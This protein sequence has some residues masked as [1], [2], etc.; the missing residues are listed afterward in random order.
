[1]PSGLSFDEVIEET[2]I[3]VVHA[4]GDTLSSYM[5]ESGS[6]HSNWQKPF[7]ILRKKPTPHTTDESGLKS[8]LREWENL[9]SKMDADYCLGP[10][11]ICRSELA[12]YDIETPRFGIRIYI[13]GIGCLTVRRIETLRNS[14][15]RLYTDQFVYEL[16]PEGTDGSGMLAD[17]LI[18]TP[19]NRQDLIWNLATT[20]LGKI[21]GLDS[22]TDAEGNDLRGIPFVSHSHATGGLCA[23]ACLFMIQSLNYKTTDAVRG[24]AEITFRA[25]SDSPQ[26]TQEVPDGK[27]KFPIKGMKR[28]Q[29]LGY[30]YRSFKGKHEIVSDVIDKIRYPKYAGTIQVPNL[31]RIALEAYS[32]SRIPQIACIDMKKLWCDQHEKVNPE[33]D[34]LEL[35]D[36]ENN[37]HGLAVIGTRYS[38]KASEVT[39]S[40]VFND[41]ALG[42]LRWC[43]SNLL[44]QSAQIPDDNKEAQQFKEIVVLPSKMKVGLLTQPTDKD[45]KPS[46]L[47]YYGIMNFRDPD[48][49]FKYQASPK[50]V[51]ENLVVIAV[52]PDDLRTDRST[53][54]NKIIELSLCSKLPAKFHGQIHEIMNTQW[55]NILNMHEPND[56]ELK[57]NKRWY[58]LFCNPRIEGQKVAVAFMKY[59]AYDKRAQYT[60]G[61][62]GLVGY[63]DYCNA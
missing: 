17:S 61:D 30:M 45:L 62:D 39:E 35:D 7:Q 44:I 19:E 57:V 47:L 8:W 33:I 9:L 29:I 11:M 38:L 52:G 13:Q 32:R 43:S 4:I 1:M 24:L 63:I 6:N 59:G 3:G 37:N 36:Q 10:S 16:L 34:A 54:T 20:N 27:V 18:L 12:M 21:Y 26:E 14:L 15:K 53:D 28:R 42:P 50:Q 41:P 55:Q 56:M 40:I 5:A 25:L 60:K 48:K 22:V 2:G 46:S 23:Q 31:Q 58:W 49:R 51:A